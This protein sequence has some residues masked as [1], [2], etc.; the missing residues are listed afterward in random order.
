M[1]YR[2][3]SPE[4]PPTQRFLEWGATD[5]ELPA[6]LSRC[7]RSPAPAGDP[8]RE[9]W[10]R[11]LFD[12]YARTLLRYAM[13]WLRNEADSEEVVIDTFVLAAH[14]LDRYDRQRSSPRGWLY[15][16]A[17]GLIRNRRRSVQR[18]VA[19]EEAQADLGHAFDE[20][21]LD[22]DLSLQQAVALLPPEL[23][24]LWWLRRVEGLSIAETAVALDVAEGTVASRLHR[25]ERIIHALI[26]DDQTTGAG[27][28]VLPL[29]L[30]DALDP[31][32][33]RELTELQ[34]LPSRDPKAQEDLW[35]RIR[36]RLGPVVA[37]PVA[38]PVPRL[39]V[40]RS[41]ASH[42]LAASVGAIA[43]WSI[44]PSPQTVVVT[45]PQVT[46]S[47]ATT[48]TPRHEAVPASVA[49]PSVAPVPAA[50]DETAA[51]A[52]ARPAPATAVMVRENGDD[53]LTHHLRRARNALERRDAPSAMAA[54]DEA[55]RAT[56]RGDSTEYLDSLQIEAVALGGDTNQ[57][58]RLL[59][60]F[61]DRYPRSPHLARL[62]GR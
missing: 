12:Q 56:P 10:I 17:C 5:A 13:S 52:H 35:R 29:G 39:L 44:L 16:L 36:R 20:P 23:R 3:S 42:A 4:P 50:T 51:A 62:Q 37:A 25:A 21:T 1:T 58:E 32:V 28:M 30:A 19:H 47:A 6:L 2:G 11:H 54:L 40:F 18:R 60:A 8:P 49:V 53:P 34:Q 31:R 38:P 59:R 24:D 43:L 26:Y 61:A 22:G 57:A 41:V 55:R 15:V 45:P 46:V 48:L 14:Q 33:E 27:A 7:A 9:V